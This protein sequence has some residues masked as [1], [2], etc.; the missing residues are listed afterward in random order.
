MRH[1]L[2][3]FLL[4]TVSYCAF[5]QSVQNQGW[6]F[7]NHKQQLDQHFDLLTD[8]Q[9]RSADR[10]DYLTTVLLRTGISYNFNKKHSA[11]LGYA[12]KYDQE[13]MDGVYDRSYENRIFEQYLFN[14]KIRR[15]EMMF[16]ARLE[17]RWL[18]E[19]TIH[20]AQ[21]GR[22]FL[23]AQIPLIADSAFTKGMYAGVQD[24]IFLNLQGKK[25]VNNSTFDQN[26]AFVS[27]GYRWSKKIDTEIGY[28][29][30][31]QRTDEANVKTNV[32]QLMITTS[33]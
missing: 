21:R 13:L 5:G 33:F 23:S 24:E 11:A 26:R 16:R 7:I 17:Q 3:A 10:Y 18:D 4:L 25:Q 14:F 6:L 12:Y 28:M 31:L 32:L 15:T 9:L 1:T 8:V 2:F 29:Y 27:L 20:F 30:W 19:Q 22:A